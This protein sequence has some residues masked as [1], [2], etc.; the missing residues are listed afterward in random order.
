M[1]QRIQRGQRRR[2]HGQPRDE[3]RRDSESV[4]TKNIKL[5]IY[6]FQQCDVKRCTGRKLLRFGLVSSLDIRRNFRGIILTPTGSTAFSPQDAEIVL[7]YGLATI[8][9]SWA[10][11]DQVPFEKLSK[12]QPRLLPFLVAANPTKYG[13]PLQLSCVE[14]F[15]AALT[16]IHKREEAERLLEKFGWGNSFWQVNQSYLSAYEACTTSS[17]V[18]SVQFKFLEGL[19]RNKRSTGNEELEV[20]AEEVDDDP[21]LSGNPNHSTQKPDPS[22]SE[23]SEFDDCV[24]YL[25]NSSID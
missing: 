16:I 4:Q 8:D 21:F 25:A 17:E 20:S 24:Q 11:L 23:D 2:A 15:A 13:K 7:K 10:K 14:A 5:F 18:V 9:C 12:A 1:T 6:D 19:E 3:S 22:G